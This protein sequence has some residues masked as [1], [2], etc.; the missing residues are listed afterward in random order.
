[1]WQWVMAV[2]PWLWWLLAGLVWLAEW[3]GR[4]AALVWLWRCLRRS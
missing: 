2:G 4:T 1:M 3:A